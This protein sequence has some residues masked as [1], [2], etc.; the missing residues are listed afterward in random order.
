MQPSTPMTTLGRFV[1]LAAEH[2]LP[3]WHVEQSEGRWPV[4]VH[5]DNGQ[6]VLVHFAWNS[7]GKATIAALAPDDADGFERSWSMWSRDIEA[8]VIRVDVA[9]GAKTFA[10]EIKRRLFPKI[11]KARAIVRPL[12]EA[13]AEYRAAERR[14]RQALLAAF[15]GATEHNGKVYLRTTAARFEYQGSTHARFSL[16][17]KAADLASF[18]QWVREHNPNVED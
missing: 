3:G 11:E 2:F 16:D 10:N 6:R 4:L 12:L 1:K 14:T 18:A 5:D 8:P 15:P 13:A 7:K 9:R 17:V